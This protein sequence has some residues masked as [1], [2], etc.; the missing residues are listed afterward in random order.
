MKRLILILITSG[1][2]IALHGENS[3]SLLQ[4]THH[5]IVKNCIQPEMLKYW[6][7]TP[8]IFT[9]SVNGQALKPGASLKVPLQENNMVVRYDYSFAKGFRTGAKEVTFKLDSTNAQCDLKFSWDNEFRIIASSGKPQ[10]VKR[11]KFKA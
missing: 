2:V 10:K 11:L 4:N 1:Q 5:R 9:L 7:Y 6:S 3:S 8:D